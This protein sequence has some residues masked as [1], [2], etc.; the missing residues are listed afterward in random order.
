M[1]VFGAVQFKS[2]NDGGVEIIHDGTHQW[3]STDE[4]SEL[5]SWLQYHQN[6]SYSTKSNR[7]E[8]YAGLAPAVAAEAQQGF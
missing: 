2:S 1:L 5:I 8:R 6:R 3:L 4:T 7:I